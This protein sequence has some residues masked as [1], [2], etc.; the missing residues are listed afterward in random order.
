MILKT[1]K[2]KVCKTVFQ[3]KTPLH[4]ICSGACA[5]KHLIAQ[6]EKKKAK[7]LTE[8]KRE[9]KLKLDAMKSINDL[10]KE[11]QTAFNAFIRERDKNELCICCDKTYGTNHLGGDFDAGHYRSRGAAGHLRFNEDNCFGQR[12]YCNTYLSGNVQGMRQGMIKRIGIDRVVAIETNNTTHKWTREELVE[13]K[14][15]YKAKLKELKKQE[16]LAA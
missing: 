8:S 9:T 15:T 13:I 14:A 2:C 1:R 10:I 12:K 5:T 3:K 4:S 16:R 6:N 11:A 7:A